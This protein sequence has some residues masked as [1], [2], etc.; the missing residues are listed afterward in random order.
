M[1]RRDGEGS[2][3]SAREQSGLKPD[4]FLMK[5]AGF[6][7]VGADEPDRSQPYPVAVYIIDDGTEYKISVPSVPSGGSILADKIE[8]FSVSTTNGLR[9]RIVEWL[10]T[11]YAR[12]GF[13]L[14]F[15][16]Y[17]TVSERH[18]R[19][20]KCRHGTLDAQTTPA[21]RR[22]R[23]SSAQQPVYCDKCGGAGVILP[24]FMTS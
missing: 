10:E 18:P 9:R 5:R 23:A 7:K 4:N 1:V 21:G 6:K 12:H 19:C 20:E 24:G 11:N 16:F 14:G 8:P 17:T 3:G 2:A 15:I 13:R 22:A